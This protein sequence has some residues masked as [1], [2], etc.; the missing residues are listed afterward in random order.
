[1]FSYRGLARCKGFAQTKVGEDIVKYAPVRAA[2]GRERVCA[3]IVAVSLC[4]Y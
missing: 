4:T 1:M 3:G 2:A